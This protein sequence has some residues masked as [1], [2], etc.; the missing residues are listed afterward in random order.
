MASPNIPLSHAKIPFAVKKSDGEIVSI[1]DV[2]NGLACDCVCPACFADLVGRKGEARLHHF[3]HYRKSQDLCKYAAETS[4]RLMLLA[5]LTHQRHPESRPIIGP[6][7]AGEVTVRNG[8]YHLTEAYHIPRRPIGDV[9]IHQQQTIYPQVLLVFHESLHPE[10]EDVCLGLYLPPAD[11]QSTEPPAWLGA[12]VSHWP[13]RGLLTVDYSILYSFLSQRPIDT[14]VVGYLLDT[15]FLRNVALRWLHHPTE[16]RTIG[17]ITARLTKTLAE[18]AEIRR[19]AEE[20]V[21]LWQEAEAQRMS[22]M[23]AEQKRKR[24]A[25]ALRRPLAIRSPV[26]P[27]EC[28]YCGQLLIAPSAA[29]ICDRQECIDKWHAWH[30]GREQSALRPLLSPEQLQEVIVSTGKCP[31]FAPLLNGLQEYRTQNGWL[32]QTHQELWFIYSEYLP[33]ATRNIRYSGGMRTGYSIPRTSDFDRAL[34]AAIAK[35]RW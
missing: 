12:F 30:D 23:V 20:R 11:Q 1:D 2:Q 32:V 29:Q 26:A 27:N 17:E 14:P 33:S 5:E 10:D 25:Q 21:K 8:R 15:L 35:L 28:R 13:R 16:S 4:I 31:D 6:D 18:E 9:F 19:D 34:N 7:I 22:R 24:E 3:A